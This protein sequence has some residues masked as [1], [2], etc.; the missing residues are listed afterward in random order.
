MCL[1]VANVLKH[2]N[3]YSEMA[4]IQWKAWI[5]QWRDWGLRLGQTMEEWEADIGQNNGEVGN[6]EW[7]KQWKIGEPRLGKTMVRCRTMNGSNN[8]RL[9]SLDWAN[10]W[11]G[12]VPRFSQTL[13]YGALW[14]GQHAPQIIY[15]DPYSKWWFLNSPM[16]NS[17]LC[18]AKH[19]GKHNCLPVMKAKIWE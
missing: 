11:R 15:C 14:F 17:T 9:G 6:N 12:G 3:K 18:I 4:S 2:V 8:G 1:A 19:M 7:V 13:E 16:S 10:Q 5:N